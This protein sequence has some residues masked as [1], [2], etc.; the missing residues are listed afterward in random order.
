MNDLV[1]LNF[2]EARQP[3]Y[4]EKRGKGYIEF[5]EKNDYPSY[6]LSLYNKSAKHNA[7]VK[8]KVNYIIGNGWKTDEVDPIAEQFIAQGRCLLTLKSLEVLTLKLFGP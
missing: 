2:Q 5:G 3:E 4:R 6:L 1:I 7:I 8:G